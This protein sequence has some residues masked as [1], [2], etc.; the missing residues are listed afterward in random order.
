[1]VSRG[2]TGAADLSGSRGPGT[3]ARRMETGDRTS[4][5][6]G[7]GSQAAP[8]SGS[9]S[10]EL[11]HELPERFVELLAFGETSGPPNSVLSAARQSD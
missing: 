4:R 7:S 2:Q 11:A 1:M 8:V 9:F 6:K 3:R 5:K 10:V